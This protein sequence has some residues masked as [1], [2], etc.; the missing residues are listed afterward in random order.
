MLD[1]A[2]E[3]LATS[4][5]KPKGMRDWES[6]DGLGRT[7]DPDPDAS[8][9]AATVSLRRDERDV[10][11]EGDSESTRLTDGCEEAATEEGDA[12]N[13]K[14]PIVPLP[15]PL[16]V[17]LSPKIGGPKSKTSEAER[18]LAASSRGENRP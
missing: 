10:A 8:P 13:S 1:A 16:P 18:E 6:D 14:S 11:G 9:L 5:K 4:E 3:P 7:P 17:P 2:P 15:L 12:I